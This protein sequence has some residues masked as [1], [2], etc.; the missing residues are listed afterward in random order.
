MPPVVQGSTGYSTWVEVFGVFMQVKRG[1]VTIR[2]QP[3]GFTYRLEEML[4]ICITPLLF[5][6]VCLRQAKV[7]LFSAML[8]AHICMLGTSRLQLLTS[9]SMAKW[10]PNSHF[11]PRSIDPSSLSDRP[12]HKDPSSLFIISL[13]TR[14]SRA[15]HLSIKSATTVIRARS[16][17]R[18]MIVEE[19]NTRC[20]VAIS[21]QLHVHDVVLASRVA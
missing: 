21:S 13:V 8:L 6:Q 15:S 12:H 16:R 9:I 4:C 14:S 5:M 10:C 11:H 17:R 20:K 1:S 7:Y 2:I 3:I 18:G 19:A